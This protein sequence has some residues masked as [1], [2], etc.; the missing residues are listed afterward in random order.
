MSKTENKRVTR[1][2]SIISCFDGK[3]M[4]YAVLIGRFENPSTVLGTWLML[5]I[6]I[7]LNRYFAAQVVLC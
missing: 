2:H 5:G 3:A 1:C 7:W 4:E 6:N